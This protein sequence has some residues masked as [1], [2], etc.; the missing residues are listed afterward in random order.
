MRFSFI[1]T[2]KQKILSVIVFTILFTI[3][4][5]SLIA[6]PSIKIIKQLSDQIYEQRIELEQMYQKGKILK[7]TLHEYEQIKPIIPSLSRVYLTRG[8]ELEFITSLEELATTS[9]VIEDKKLAAPDPKKV[10]NQLQYQL[11]I[12]GDLKG[13]IRYLAALEALDFYVNINTVRLSTSTAQQTINQT[14]TKP[15]LQ[16]ILLATSFYKP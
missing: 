8:N 15:A 12:S 9:G 7:K 3:A 4:I 16:A 13:F 11:Q 5:F 1:H 14:V 6:Y 2:P 10:T